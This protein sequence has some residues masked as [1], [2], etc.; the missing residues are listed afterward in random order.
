MLADWPRYLPA[1]DSALVIEFG[2]TIDPAINRLVHALDAAFARARVPGVGCAIPT[3]R[4]LLVQYNPLLLDYDQV[5][6]IARARVSSLGEEEPAPARLVEIPTVYGGAHGPDL[7]EI[8]RLH[9]MSEAE[10]VRLHASREYL[11][12]MIGFSPGFPYL[13]GMDEAIA[14]PR[15]KNPRT[16]VPAG[17]VGI[18]GNQTGI[19]SIDSPGGWRLIGRT[20]LRL[21]DPRRDPPSLLAPGDRLRFVPVRED[22]DQ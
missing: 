10:V 19:Y 14:T 6:E 5:L 15:L 1:G 9:S 17:S 2:D 7:P 4:S 21:F 8:A 13:G 11:I 20:A 12:Y 18:A 22:E 3:Y 16:L